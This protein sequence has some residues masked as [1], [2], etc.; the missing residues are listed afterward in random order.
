MKP[1]ISATEITTSALMAMSATTHQA[2]R[3][4]VK[5]FE[6]RGGMFFFL[7]A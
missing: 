5:V 6:V 2:E 4:G 3:G 1:V 7:Q